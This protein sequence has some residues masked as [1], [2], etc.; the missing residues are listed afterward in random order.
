MDDIRAGYFETHHGLVS[1][2][3]SDD[4]HPVWS[5]PGDIRSRWRSLQVQGKTPAMALM[6]VHL[7]ANRIR[8]PADDETT[9]LGPLVEILGEYKEQ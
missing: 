8:H 9:G 3:L 2:N 1:A 4:L 5:I 7:T 6:A